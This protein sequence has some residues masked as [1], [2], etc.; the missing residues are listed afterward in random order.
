MVN[1][2]KSN[3]IDTEYDYGVES[4]FE[5]D[6]KDAQAYHRRALQF[7]NEG[8]AFSVVFNVASVALER[9]LVALC[10]LYGEEPRNHNF[11]TLMMTAEKLLEVP[12]ELSKEVKSLDQ[13]FGICFLDTY[14]HGDPVEADTK[15]TLRMCNDVKKLFS[16]EKMQFIRSALKQVEQYA[17]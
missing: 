13:I 17:Q 16:Q 4:L 11:I 7:E 14:F 6:F 12:K 15:R 9:Y 5:D 2:E 3:M 8:E 1:L 10:E